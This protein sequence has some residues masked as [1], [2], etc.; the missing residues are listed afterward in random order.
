MDL[1]INPTGV[2]HEIFFDLH[3]FY[4]PVFNPF[5]SD[6]GKR[7][8]SKES[9]SGLVN[10]VGTAI[11]LIITLLVVP[12]ISYF[13]GTS[14]GLQELAALKSLLWIL[15]VAW[16]SCFVLGELTGN[17]SQVDKLW[18]LLPIAYAW[19]VTAHGNYSPRLLLMAILVTAWGLR[20]TFN[21]SRHGGYRFS[22][23][24]GHED[25]R[26]QVLRQKSEFQPRWKWTLFNLSFISGY[27]N[28]L[29]MLITLPTIVALQY[30]GTPLGW[31]DFSAA[32]L[33]SFMLLIETVA[34]QQQW[35][36]Q[37]AKK[38]LLKAGQPL[39]GEYAK[40][41]LDTGLWAWS[42][43][44]NYFA[45]QGIWVAF[46]LFSIAASGQWIN[47]SISGGILL[48][49][50]FSGSSKFSE[51]ISAGKYPEYA[52]YQKTVPRFIPFKLF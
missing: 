43:H 52:H 6:S 11:L 37:T 21:F 34:D 38:A 2:C 8:Q 50:L 16:I 41:F 19:T 39:T 28:I 10:I 46:Y 3:F 51:E 9:Y 7:A 33:M 29:I 13:T 48:L 12:V 32:I 14:L 22:F 30:A 44:P 47:W 35:R 27:Q 24:N 4:S 49:I 18:S 23:W 5:N 20:L 15:L 26:W 45:E 31:L 40:G 25:Y 42:R 17:V 1:H 36:Y